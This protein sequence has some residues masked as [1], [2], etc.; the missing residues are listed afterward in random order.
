MS[1]CLKDEGGRLTK[2]GTSSQEEEATGTQTQIQE[3]AKFCEY[4]LFVDRQ[5]PQYG[6]SVK[7]TLGYG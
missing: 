2:G 6:L 5:A 4:D 1:E 7:C 3:K